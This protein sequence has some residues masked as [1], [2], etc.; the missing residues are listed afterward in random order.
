MK[1]KQWLE[2][3][4]EKS[5]PILQPNGEIV[6]DYWLSY[7]QV[8]EGE[9]VIVANVLNLELEDQPIARQAHEGISKQIKQEL[10]SRFNV[11]AHVVVLDPEEGARSSKTFI[12]R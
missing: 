10:E 5:Y 9:V 11:L 4:P 7:E 6:I 8:D 2:Q 1:I 12:P 3:H